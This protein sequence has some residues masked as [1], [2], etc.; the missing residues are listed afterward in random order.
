MVSLRRVPCTQDRTSS[1]AGLTALRVA[2][3]SEVGALGN[4]PTIEGQ[5]DRGSTSKRV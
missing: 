5:R 4:V 1:S 2:V 3:F